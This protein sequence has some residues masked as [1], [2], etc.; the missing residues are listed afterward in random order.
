MHLEDRNPSYQAQE[1]QA[2]PTLVRRRRSSTESTRTLGEHHFPRISRIVKSKRFEIAIGVVIIANCITMGMEAE[3]LLGRAQD[4]ES[5]AQVSELF[6]TFIFLAELVLR[7][8]VYGWKNFA[9]LPGTVWNFL[10]AILVLVTGVVTGI[11]PLIGVASGADS[12]LQ[13]LT[14]LRAFRLARLVRVVQKFE[15]FHEVWLLL[16]GLMESG[17][18][19]FWTVVVIFFITYM[20]A[21]FGVVLLGVHIKKEYDDATASRDGPS[22]E[23]EALFC[24]TGGVWPLMYTLIQVLTLDSWNSIARPMMKYVPWSWCYFYLY[25]A[26]AVIVMMNLVTAVIVENA[27]KNSQKDAN[28][29]LREKEK[30]KQVELARIRQVFEDM[31]INGDGELSWPE[32]ESAFDDKE[33]SAKLNLL[34]MEPD[35][36]RDI[37]QLLDTGDG[38][39]SV[40]EFFDGIVCME[41]TANAKDLLRTNKT[42]DLVV[43]LLCQQ[44]QELREDLDQLLQ[45]TPGAVFRARNG[46]LK[47]RARRQQTCDDVFQTKSVT[48]ESVASSPS[49]IAT[50]VPSF[51]IRHLEQETLSDVMKRLEQVVGMVHESKLESK[52]ALAVCTKSFE[53]CTQKIFTLNRGMCDLKANLSEGS[54]QRHIQECAPCTPI[55]SPR[56]HW[57]SSFLSGRGQLPIV[58]ELTSPV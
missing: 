55:T 34:G 44:N 46:S 23:L 14:V 32:F 54:P 50:R 8:L 4:F 37:F 58:P 19:L 16:R 49:A 22:D 38:V 6:I 27:L 39:L 40:Q 24:V 3:L 2:L 18:V 7:V 51:A 43:K 30:Q 15:A 35:N 29:L 52:E 11:L 25:I 17:R 20:F 5:T 28:A 45:L 47:S 26:I 33:L 21:V 57:R 13:T 42:V 36:C 1:P 10:D 31:D 41:G 12:S 53:S 48:S 9:P 56:S